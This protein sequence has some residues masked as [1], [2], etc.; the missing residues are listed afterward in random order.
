[1]KSLIF[2][3]FFFFFFTSFKR[4]F[5][6]FLMFGFVCGVFGAMSVLHLLFNVKTQKAHRVCCVLHHLLV[7]SLGVFASKEACLFGLLLEFGFEISDTLWTVLTNLSWTGLPKSA[8]FIHHVLSAF[9]EAVVIT[10]VISD[11]SFPFEAVSPFLVILIGS[12]AVDLIWA[13]LLDFPRYSTQQYIAT[14][15]YT[16]IFFSLRIVWFW[17]ASM[18]LM[19]EISGPQSLVILS[20]VMFGVFLLYHLLLGTG[21]VFA[22]KHGG[23]MPEK[24]Q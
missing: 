24:K 2:L 19:H 4:M 15:I 12:G 1:M 17:T 23:K 7:A 13:K 3:F 8:V 9:L 22:W 10:F 6:G 18:N 21:I 20:R 5:E 16:F 11:D 14:A